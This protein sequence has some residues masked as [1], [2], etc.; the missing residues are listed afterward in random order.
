MKSA[1]HPKIS[2]IICAYN[3]A[4]RI[5]NVLSV[6]STFKGFDEVIVVDDGSSDQTYAVASTFPVTVLKHEK[7]KGKAAA[8]HTGF[9]KSRGEIIVLLDSDLTGLTHKN[10]TSLL[11][12]TLREKCATFVLVANTWPIFHV[13]GVDAWTG[14]RAFPRKILE[15]VFLN[16]HVIQQKY[17]IECYI[18][19][20][21]L[22][23]KLP[24]YSISWENVINVQKKD[25]EEGSLVGRFKDLKM[26]W[27]VYSSFGFAP[28]LL[29]QIKIP[30][31]ARTY[32]TPA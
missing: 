24:I 6:V 8:M 11:E 15:D 25:K 13:E 1:V 19:Q 16:P 22:K 30:R 3:E 23:N 10:L 27:N 14:E 17:S 9:V 28:T 29:Q 7:N 4:A 21:I 20:S 5:G 18:N 2:C 12:P 31:I 26:F 32:K